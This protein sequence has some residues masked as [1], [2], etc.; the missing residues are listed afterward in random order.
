MALYKEITTDEGLT[1]NYHRIV[2]IDS[3]IN[4]NISIC[5]HSYLSENMREKQKSGDIPSPYT[6]GRTYVHDYVEN[7]TIQD[8]YDYLTTLDDFEGA[9][10]I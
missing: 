10:K 3:V 6:R 4:S 7:F 1:L 2:F 8:A 5:V 9:T